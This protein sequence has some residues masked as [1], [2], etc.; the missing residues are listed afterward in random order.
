[1]VKISINLLPP[2][3]L[4]Q[5]L[6]KAKFYKIQAAGI[7]VVLTL[8]F[9]TSLTVALGILQSRNI[10]TA[11]AQATQAE[12]KVTNLK[13]TQAALLLLDDRLKAINEYWGASSKQSSMYKLI[14]KLVPASIAVTAITID[15]SSEAVFSVA[16]PDSISLD[17]FIVKLTAKEDNEGKISQV[18]LDSL[19]RGR[20]GL[21][22]VSFTV[23]PK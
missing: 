15:R 4:E 5:Q 6:K 20:D 9:L 19:N 22:R 7:V 12:Q 16:A 2:E 17:D 10:S 1:M 3:I 8:V 21:Y 13:N 14:T 23:K 18:A 11:S